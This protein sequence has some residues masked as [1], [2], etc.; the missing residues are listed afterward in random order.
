MCGRLTQQL[1]SEEIARLFGAEAEVED[2]GGHFNVAPTQHIRAVVDRTSGRVV[3]ALR[4]GLIPSWADDPKVGARMINARAE[5][6]A[7]K[8][9]F[10]SAFRRQRCIVPADA[11]YEWQ[12]TTA[13]KVPHAIVRQDGKLL[14]FAGLWATWQDPRADQRISSCAIITTAANSA[15]SR[16]HDRMPAILP[17]DAWDLWLDVGDDKVPLLQSLLVPAPDD[18]LRAYPVS[19]LVNDVRNDGPQ[20]I[21]PAGSAA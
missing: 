3:T 19:R 17:D 8:P 18:L 9:A 12:Q 4:W 15:M 13:G 10:R 6:V 2:L 11:Y 20:L 7:E 16:I 1:S 14:A 5:T 21:V